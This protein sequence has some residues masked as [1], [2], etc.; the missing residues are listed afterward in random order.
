[1]NIKKL[2]IKVENNPKY[3]TWLK[4]CYEYSKKSYHPSTHNAALLI[5]KNKI[6][7]KGVNILPKGVK[8]IKKRF[9]GKDKHIYSNHAER[10]L[11]YKAALKGIS[12]TLE[13]LLLV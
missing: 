8:K 2:K 5:K 10:D 6:I 1:M 12:R 9:K 3:K 7:L 4:E 11:V 13:I